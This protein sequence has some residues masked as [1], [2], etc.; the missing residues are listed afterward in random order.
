[1]T[2]RFYPNASGLFLNRNDVARYCEAISRHTGRLPSTRKS[3]P[4]DATITAKYSELTLRRLKN[5]FDLLGRSLRFRYSHVSL[6]KRE[7]LALFGSDMAL[8][9]IT[10]IEDEL[11]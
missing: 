8:Q 10:D 1:M 7:Q 6:K 5:L 11:T 4:L 3:S 9:Q 2:L